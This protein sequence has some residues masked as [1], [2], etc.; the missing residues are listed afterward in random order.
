M[1]LRALGAVT[2]LVIGLVACAPLW[3]DPVGERADTERESPDVPEALAATF[4]RLVAEDSSGEDRRRAAAA[5]LTGEPR[6]VTAHLLGEALSSRYTTGVWG[7]TLETLALHPVAPPRALLPDLLA[8][9]ERVDGAAR[10]DLAAA[11]GRLMDESLAETLASRARDDSRSLGARRTAI[12]ALGH[13]RTQETAGLLVKLTAPTEPTAVQES[14]FVAL[15]TL[16]GHVH[17]DA[18][19]AAWTNWW[20]EARGMSERLWQ[21]QVVDNLGR[22]AEWHRAERAQLGAR[23]QDVVRRQ[24]HSA[25]REQRPAM[26]AALLN[27]P[28]EPV[29]ELAISLAVQRLVDG[30]A[31]DE[32]LRT[33]LRGLLEDPAVSIR[34]RATL[35]L[36]DLADGPAADRVAQRL[37]AERE[38][39]VA[40][41]RADLLM[42]TRLP[43]GAAVVPVTA[44]LDHPSLRGEAAGMLAAAAE[45][46]LIDGEQRERIAARVRAGL[47]GE[48][49]LAE[50]VRLLGRVGGEAD[51]QRIAAWLDSEDGAVKQAAARAWA[52]SNRP[53]EP[54]AARAGDAQ[55]GPVFVLAAAR[56][57]HTAETL[58]ALAAHRPE[59]ASQMENW[60]RALVSVAERAPSKAVLAAVTDLE[61]AEVPPTVREAM[62]TAAVQRSEEAM[63]AVRLEEGDSIT[64]ADEDDAETDT[65][66]DADAVAET[67]AGSGAPRSDAMLELAPLALEPA[68]PALLV[69]QLEQ[70]TALRVARGEVRLEAG[71]ADAAKQDFESVVESGEALPAELHR[72]AALGLIRAHLEVGE[73]NE[74]ATLAEAHLSEADE[75]S[76]LDAPAV[77]RCFFEAAQQRLHAEEL[78]AARALVAVLHEVVEV[79]QSA[80]REEMD[81]LDERVAQLERDLRAADDAEPGANGGEP[82]GHASDSPMLPVPDHGVNGGASAETAPR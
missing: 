33:A 40:V 4:D 72:A 25:E 59:S 69:H 82:A 22:L 81:G 34:Q 41:L 9:A 65:D 61:R 36:R 27:D 31:F 28:L 70:Y 3:A 47:D 75:A 48:A 60:Q 49:P 35:L 62:L 7:A 21:R 53:L 68:D 19:R 32:P 42:L 71:R 2:L 37:A 38:S 77:V 74:A 30:G 78:D 5:L 76:P 18:D 14:A 11:I 46:G 8:M 1:S 16:T 12:L 13:H 43:R 57:G 44:M 58:H 64:P 39:V 50:V 79:V 20:D 63:T 55:I 45:A 26:L 80:E 66:T 29:R 67:A 52:Q 6:E 56:R 24:Y 15:Q 73:L 17:F 51:W 54:L 23:L 10:R